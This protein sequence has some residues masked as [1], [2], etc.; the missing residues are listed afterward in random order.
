MLKSYHPSDVALAKWAQSKGMYKNYILSNKA[1]GIYTQKE[2][3]AEWKKVMIYKAAYKKRMVANARVVITTRAKLMKQQ[4]Q[5]LVDKTYH[6]SIPM[7]WYIYKE[8]RY[9]DYRVHQN[10]YINYNRL[11]YVLQRYNDWILYRTN[12]FYRSGDQRI[13][14]EYALIGNEKIMWTTASESQKRERNMMVGISN[15]VGRFKLPKTDNKGVFITGKMDGTVASTHCKSWG[16]CRKLYLDQ[17][18]AGVTNVPYALFYGQRRYWVRYANGRAAKW[19]DI[20]A[21]YEGIWSMLGQHI[22]N[23]DKSLEKQGTGNDFNVKKSGMIIQRLF[24][25]YYY[26]Y[27]THIQRSGSRTYFR[28]WGYRTNNLHQALKWYR[29]KPQWW[30]KVKGESHGFWIRVGNY[31]RLLEEN[32]ATSYQMKAVQ[33]GYIGYYITSQMDPCLANLKQFKSRNVVEFTNKPNT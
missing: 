3:A 9:T 10:Q 23:E 18:N 28:A 30:N 12:W 16:E 8:E 19:N 2:W 21:K 11:D 29:H 4:R 25:S 17:Q 27:T 5:I 15:W 7:A 31:P 33:R 6:F 20:V 26:F 13:G 22:M 1:S 14:P 32:K 24:R